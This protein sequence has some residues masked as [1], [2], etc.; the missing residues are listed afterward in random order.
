MTYQA[1]HNVTDHPIILDEEGHQ[2]GGGEWGIA[3]PTSE[4]TAAALEAGDLHAYPSIA[5]GSG[6]NPDAV[7]AAKAASDANATLSAP[8]PPEPEPA[9]APGGGPQEG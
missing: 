7:A 5:P 1:V 4:L 2:L 8:P 3:D 9:P 6:Q